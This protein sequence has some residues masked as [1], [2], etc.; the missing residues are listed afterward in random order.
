MS[1]DEESFEYPKKSF[2]NAL[3][4][5]KPLDIKTEKHAER[6]IKSGKLQ[7]FLKIL[8]QVDNGSREEKGY[9]IPADSWL[10]LAVKAEKK[11]TVT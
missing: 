3:T 4:N 2:A 1:S 9:A 8:D 10:I 6:C 5:L 11:G 7:E